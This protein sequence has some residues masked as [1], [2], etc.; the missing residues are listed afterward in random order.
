MEINKVWEALG[1]LIIANAIVTL[2]LVSIL[3]VSILI[4]LFRRK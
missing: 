2:I 4:D 1:M 3:F